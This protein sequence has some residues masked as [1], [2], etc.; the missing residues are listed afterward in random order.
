MRLHGQ[1]EVLA[2]GSSA[3]E[4]AAWAARTAAERRVAAAEA[5]LAVG[6]PVSWLGQGVAG[7][8]LLSLGSGSPMMLCSAQTR[9]LMHHAGRGG[10]QGGSR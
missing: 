9:C 4:A 5:A 10:S 7:C 2:D 6:E 3:K 1:G 8:T